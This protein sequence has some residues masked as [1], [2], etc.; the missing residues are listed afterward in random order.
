DGT[1]SL[2]PAGRCPGAAGAPGG[3][4]RSQLAGDRSKG[5]GMM[6]E[7]DVP[8]G[9]D[10]LRERLVTTLA[11]PLG[12]QVN[13]AIAEA[14]AALAP[15][16]TR[17]GERCQAVHFTRSMQC[18]LPARHGGEHIAGSGEGETRW[19]TEVADRLD[20]SLAAT[21][22]APETREPD[23]WIIEYRFPD[24]TAWKIEP[25]RVVYATEG[26]A[27]Y[28]MEA[29]RIGFPKIAMRIRKVFFGAPATEASDESARCT[30]E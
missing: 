15:Q 5:G 13:R 22:P 23:G 24:S 20:A 30:C 27:A 1:G 26:D 14:E 8:A 19:T 28:R 12:V 3:A 7:H 18:K 25:G 2:R 9:R 11:T 10:E 17:E 21:R 6:S 29:V 16:E 4:L